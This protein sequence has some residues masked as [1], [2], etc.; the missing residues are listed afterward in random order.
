MTGANG[1]HS[2]YFAQSVLNAEGTRSEAHD[3]VPVPEPASL[4]LFATGLFGSAFLARRRRGSREVRER[5]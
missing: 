2:F 1:N 5:S 4:T 3:L